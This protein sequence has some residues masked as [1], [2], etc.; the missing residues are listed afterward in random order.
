MSS[1]II[2]IGTYTARQIYID[3]G[4]EYIN[5]WINNGCDGV[6]FSDGRVLVNYKNSMSYI[7]I[8]INNGDKY[9]RQFNIQDGETFVF[10]MKKDLYDIAVKYGLF[11]V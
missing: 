5:E 4:W 1:T 7:R 3:E 9:V 6:S 2:H 10:R 8:N 11:D